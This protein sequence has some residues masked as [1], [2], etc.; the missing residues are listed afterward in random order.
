[1]PRLLLF[2]PCEKAILAQDNSVSL[3]NLLETLTVT[4]PGDV[5][6]K[7]PAP[8]KAPMNWMVFA[9]WEQVPGDE[10]KSYE[11]ILRFVLPDGQIAFEGVE[12]FEM[13]QR[14]IRNIAAI[15]G[16]PAGQAGD[17]RLSLSLRE[18]S[19][20]G[21]PELIAEFPLIVVHQ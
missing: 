10:N 11:Q 18:A 21:R 19:A 20:Q 14:F 6:S 2:I 3:I 17:C 12:K 1:M 13:T 8:L 16:V 7:L 15:D 5:K 4:L 9:L